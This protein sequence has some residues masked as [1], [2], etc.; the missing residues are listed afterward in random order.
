MIAA[1]AR[2]SVPRR[3][4]SSSDPRRGPHHPGAVKQHQPAAEPSSIQRD[5]TAARSRHRPGA[6][7]T[8]NRAGRCGVSAAAGLSRRQFGHEMRAAL[9]SSPPPSAADLRVYRP[10]PR[11]PSSGSTKVRRATPSTS[12]HVLLLD[13]RAVRCRRRRR[14]IGQEVNGRSNFWRAGRRIWPCGLMPHTSASLVDGQAAVAEH[15]LRSCNGGV[16][17]R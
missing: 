12:C 2:C 7:M 13:P 5:G 3:A 16:I 11:D 10:P 17:G 6:A 1:A 14:L 15:R 9:E 8:M 4:A